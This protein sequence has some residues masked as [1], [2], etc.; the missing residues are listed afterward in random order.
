MLVT[1]SPS[2]SEGI[3]TSPPGP[4]YPVMVIVPPLS[5]YSK[6][7]IGLYSTDVITDTIFDVPSLS[8]PVTTRRKR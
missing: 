5:V 2:I 6:S 1:G 8:P 7:S 3:I 4:I